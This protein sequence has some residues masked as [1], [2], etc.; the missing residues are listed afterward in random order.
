MENATKA[1]L[2]AAAVL[3]AI[4]LIS[5]GIGVFTSASE[6]MG[7]MDLSGYQIQEHN[8]KFTP[9]VG[10]SV[11]A[12]DVNALLTTLFN[13]NLT[14]EDSST[15]VKISA[16]GNG[17]DSTLAS[18]E[19]TNAPTQSYKRVSTGY[20]YKVEATYKSGIIKEIKITTLA[21]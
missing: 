15:R 13:H 12:S 16:S 7:D 11:S 3:V 17:I 4:L 20:R 9:Y 6:Q 10:D 1:L 14:Q 18:V 8:N 2:I 19:T 5:L 21:E